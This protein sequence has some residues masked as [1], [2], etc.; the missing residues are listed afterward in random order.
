MSSF[1]VIIGEGW[2]ADCVAEELS[3]RY[4]VFRRIDF[5]NGLPENSELMLVLH[6]YWNPIAHQKAEEA[7]KLTGS[8]WLRAFVSFGEGIIGPLV[9]PG[10][11]GCLQCAD[12]RKL[13]GGQERSEMRKVKRKLEAEKETPSDSWA[14]KNGLLHLV[15]LIVT[16]ADKVLAGKKGLSAGQMYFTDLKH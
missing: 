10:K 8:P 16:E 6:D 12:L 11:P 15:H 1:V 2:L 7:V 4:Q 14:S 9:R 5:E 3:S 13:L